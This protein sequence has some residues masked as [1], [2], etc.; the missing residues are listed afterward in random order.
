M[1]KASKGL[2]KWASTVDPTIQLHT[3]HAHLVEHLRGNH[4]TLHPPALRTLTMAQQE[5]QLHKDDGEVRRT[6]T[7]QPIHGKNDP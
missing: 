4:Q 6:T 3:A 5:V 7:H 1:R 2:A